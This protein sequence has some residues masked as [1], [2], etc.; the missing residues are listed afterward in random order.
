MG[1]S[2]NRN[3]SRPQQ[4]YGFLIMSHYY[5]ENNG[6]YGLTEQKHDI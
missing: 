4:R 2:Q 1:D 3:A 6:A 5:P